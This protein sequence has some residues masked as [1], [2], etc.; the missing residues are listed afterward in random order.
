MNIILDKYN[1]KKQYINGDFTIPVAI[2]PIRFEFPFPGDYDNW[3][4]YQRYMVFQDWFP[5]ALQVL[6]TPHPELPGAFLTN[7]SAPIEYRGAVC[8]FEMEWARLPGFGGDG[9]R[10]WRI[11]YESYIFDYPAIFSTGLGHVHYYIDAALTET[12]PN[13][14]VKLYAHSNTVHNINNNYQ[15]ATIYYY[16]TAA[17]GYFQVRFYTSPIYDRGSTWIVVDAIP[18]ANISYLAF[19]RPIVQVA[20]RQIMMTS[21]VRYD[22]FIVGSPSTPSE[23]DIPIIQR[24]IIYDE[25]LNPTNVLHEHTHPPLFDVGT[26]EKSWR[27]MEQ[28]HD[29]ICVEPSILSRWRGN[30]FERKT[31]YV[32]L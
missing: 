24:F 10:P 16:V 23:Q 12:L 7:I 22:Y 15:T 1:R 5:E 11:E 32:R 28:D 18:G 30:I 31:R 20:S 9:N 8:E 4:A 17:S 13:N 6:G 26:S 29:L 21:E 25:N 27:Q 3:V 19:E 14:R 2:S